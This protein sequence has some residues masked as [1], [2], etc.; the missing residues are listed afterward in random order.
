MIMTTITQRR[1]TTPPPAD[2][3]IT[4]MFRDCFSVTGSSSSALVVST[5]S[6][7][8]VKATALDMVVPVVV[9]CTEEKQEICLQNTNIFDKS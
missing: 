4:A 3:I 8:V 9:N 2:P 5:S 7:M 6:V 1:K